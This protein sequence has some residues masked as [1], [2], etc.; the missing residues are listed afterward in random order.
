MSSSSC[1]LRLHLQRKRNTIKKKQTKTKELLLEIVKKPHLPQNT[2]FQCILLSAVQLG[3]LELIMLLGCACSTYYGTLR[4]RID[5]QRTSC[6]LFLWT[7]VALAV[8]R[9]G[10]CGFVD[11]WWLLADGLCNC[12]FVRSSV[13][14]SVH[15][16]WLLS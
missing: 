13:S 16:S 8:V 12:T 9:M 2:N 3:Q 15:P 11:D 1:W 10:D 5:N 4:R 7:H 6:L 14:P